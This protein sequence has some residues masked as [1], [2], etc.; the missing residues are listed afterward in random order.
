M[1][2]DKTDTNCNK[3]GC[4]DWECMSITRAEGIEHSLVSVE[5]QALRY[6]PIYHPPEKLWLGL[7]GLFRAIRVIRVRAI[8]AI[9]VNPNP[10][11]PNSPNPN[12]N[13]NFSGG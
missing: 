1:I 7:L 13:P 11:S 3:A 10:N 5:Q 6:F 8:R 4:I 12:P 2:S 9:R